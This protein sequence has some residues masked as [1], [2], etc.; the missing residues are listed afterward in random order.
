MS[1]RTYVGF[2]A[3]FPTEPIG[4]DPSGQEL[5]AFVVQRLRDAGFAVEAPGDREGW[6]W[7]FYTKYDELE[8]QSIVGLVDDME[9]QPPRQWLIT[10]DCEPGLF[11]RLFS[12]NRLAEKRK[13][14]RRRFCDSLHQIMSADSRFSHIVWYNKD[15]FDK[16]DDQPAASP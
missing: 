11:Q 10:N 12:G 16:P 9:S 13:L 2:V 15:T 1:V 5:A 14:L 8:I 3:D 6:A 7:D 4:N